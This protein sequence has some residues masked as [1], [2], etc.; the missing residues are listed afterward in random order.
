MADGK[1]IERPL[2]RAGERLLVVCGL[3]AGKMLDQ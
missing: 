1:N 2:T 3:H